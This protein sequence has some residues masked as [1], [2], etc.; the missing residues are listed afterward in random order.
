MDVQLVLEVGELIQRRVSLVICC[1]TLR[2]IE[3]NDG[4]NDGFREEIGEGPLSL[5][6]PCYGEG[7]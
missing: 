6:W 4:P 5:G 7:K 1:P 3:L 2:Q